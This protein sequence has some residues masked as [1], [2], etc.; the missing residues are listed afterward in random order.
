VK[1]TLNDP[2]QNEDMNKVKK[3]QI[4]A[5]ISGMKN[6]EYQ[7]LVNGT[8]RRK[9]KNHKNLKFLLV[10]FRPPILYQVLPPMLILLHMHLQLGRLR[11]PNPWTNGIFLEINNY[12]CS[13]KRQ[14]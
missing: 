12:N 11:T 4:Y 6:K 5:H 13:Y 2:H 1:K 14:F 10:Q 3:I 8:S 7:I 9:I